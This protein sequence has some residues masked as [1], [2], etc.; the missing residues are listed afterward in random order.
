MFRYS[1]SFISVQLHISYSGSLD[2]Q[3]QLPDSDD[4]YG[5]HV[6]EFRGKLGPEIPSEPALRDVAWGSETSHLL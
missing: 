5:S 3:T 6:Q 2:I 4:V 1:F